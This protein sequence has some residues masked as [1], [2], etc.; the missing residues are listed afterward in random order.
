[1]E[2]FLNRSNRIFAKG[3][4]EQPDRKGGRFYLKGLGRI[5][6]KTRR[7]RPGEALCKG[8]RKTVAKPWSSQ[9]EGLEEHSLSLIKD[10][11]FSEA[12]KVS[13]YEWDL[14]WTFNI[15]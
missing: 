11:V 3:R 9:E 12:R 1:M 6:A 2:F 10:S 14:S 4:P 15:G 5:L 13:Q 8:L 7:R